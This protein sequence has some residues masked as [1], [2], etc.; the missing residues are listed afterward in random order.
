MGLDWIR[1]QSH[2]Y[3]QKFTTIHKNL[4]ENTAQI[5]NESVKNTTNAGPNLVR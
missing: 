1:L 5:S 4:L 2:K 3:C